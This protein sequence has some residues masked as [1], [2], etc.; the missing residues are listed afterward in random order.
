MP[1]IVDHDARRQELVEATWRV[2]VRVGLDETTTREIAREAGCS[3]GSLAYYFKDKD[4]ILIKARE[5]SHGHVRERFVV[6]VSKLDGLAAL[7]AVVHEALPLDDERL[8]EAHIELSFWARA[9][10]NQRLHDIHEEEVEHFWSWLADLVRAARGG[11]EIDTEA[12]D[13]EIVHQ[14]MVLIDALSAQALLHPARTS[15][16][17]QVEMVDDVLRAVAT[18][19]AA[20]AVL[21]PRRR[22]PV[23][24]RRTAPIRVAST[25][26]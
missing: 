8:L 13:D 22:T 18:P 15:G 16:R 21:P 20:A 17:R 25:G 1:K 2:I 24:R 4:D 26:R 6:A 12:T 7:R 14:L 19:A 5:L 23:R 11:G 10:N 9:L 3:S